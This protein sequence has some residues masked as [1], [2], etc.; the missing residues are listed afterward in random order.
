MKSDGVDSWLRHW[1][2]MQRKGSRPLVL[3]ASSDKPSDAHGNTRKT[4]V[5]R[6]KGKKP[7][8]GYVEPD[9][10]D[11]VNNITDDVSGLL[12]SQ[13]P[14]SVAPISKSRRTF[15]TSLSDDKHYKNLLLLLFAAK[16]SNLLSKS[17]SIDKWI[18]W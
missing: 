3:K 16:V 17:T 7:N 13:S 6:R 10:D 18:G 12:F 5:D 9:E 11:E 2:K 14:R 8:A 4:L 1:L 15:L